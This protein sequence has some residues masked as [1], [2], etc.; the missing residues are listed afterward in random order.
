MLLLGLPKRRGR[1]HFGHDRLWPAA[2]GV[3]FGNF[4][5][6]G[7]LLFFALI[8]NCGP[9]LGTDV[10]HLTILLGRVVESKKKIQEFRERDGLRIE[11]N[12]NGFGVACFPCLNITVGWGT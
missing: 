6:G 1:D 9:I 10:I 4:L 5:F 7:L 11:F 8:K 3:D 12:L 2:R